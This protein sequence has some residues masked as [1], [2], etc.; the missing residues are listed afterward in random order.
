MSNFC[1]TCGP[2]D[3]DLDSMRQCPPCGEK[4]KARNTRNADALVRRGLDKPGTYGAAI[5]AA[6]AN[7]R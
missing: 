4:R 5:V 3:S 7:D 1:C 6:T 2:T